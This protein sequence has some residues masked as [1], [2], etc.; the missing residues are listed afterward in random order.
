[1][2][3]TAF[4]LLFTLCFVF[5][6]GAVIAAPINYDESSDGDL[7]YDLY[8]PAIPSFFVLDIGVNRFAGTETLMHNSSGSDSDIVHFTIPD[9]LFVSSISFASQNIDLTNLNY[10][11]PEYDLKLYDENHV[12]SASAE[13]F[14][15]DDWPFQ[16]SST[17]SS[18]LPLTAGNYGIGFYRITYA[19]PSGTSPNIATWDYTLE[20]TVDADPVPIPSA[21]FLLGSGLVG[22]I[23]IRRKLGKN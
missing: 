12:W 14:K 9:G 2:K 5:F 17:F 13:F 8:Y 16:E 3:R 18:Q 19:V 6:A 7:G 4:C 20:L 22:L 23:G 11:Y 21:V 10:A 1:M 15:I